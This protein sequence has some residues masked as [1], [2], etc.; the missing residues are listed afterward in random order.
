MISV[1]FGAQG[2]QEDASE[3]LS[4]FLSRWAPLAS[5]ILDITA[6][7]PPRKF[8]T[9]EMER[10]GEGTRGPLPQATAQSAGARAEYSVLG[11]A[12]RVMT[13]N[14]ISKDPQCLCT[15]GSYHSEQLEQH[16]ILY[17]DLEQDRSDTTLQ[18]LLDSFAAPFRVDGGEGDSC[19]LCA[20]PY[21]I[22]HQHVWQNISECQ[23]L[24]LILR[25]S[26]PVGGNIKI[27]RRVSLNVV[28]FLESACFVL[29]S[30][31]QHLGESAAAGH[32]LAWIREHNK[33]IIYDD[34]K[35]LPDLPGTRR[36]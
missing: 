15:Q 36:C 31:A 28:V 16:E 17:L 32:Y 19:P 14:S 12:M 34:D 2:R 33:F 4:L 20:K 30:F 25:R 23:S 18:G 24:F 27:R 35:Q 1:L 9:W 11:E 21:L 22:M 6:E 5:R 8:L 13:L 3:F 29:C 7:L 26:S 10:G